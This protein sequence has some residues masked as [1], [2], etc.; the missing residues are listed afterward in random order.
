MPTPRSNLIVVAYP[1]DE[2]L[3]FSSVCR[4]ATIVVVGDPKWPRH[5]KALQQELQQ[6][7]IQLKA[8]K[9]RD[10]GHTVKKVDSASFRTLVKLLRRFKATGRV[11]THSPFD[12]DALRGS[13]ALAAAQAFGEVWVQSPSGMAQHVNV[14]PRSALAAKARII[15]T[16]YAKRIRTED[17]SF[18]MPHTAL[19]GVEAF[20]PVT[21][22]EVMH[23]VALTRSE[24]LPY[25]DAW[26]LMTSP[27]ETNRYERSCQL[28]L[29]HAASSGAKT[30]LEVGACEG[31]M[32]SHLRQTFP[33]SHI[34]ALE[35]HPEFARRLKARFSKDKRT[36]VI[37]QG[38]DKAEL[39]ADIVL[40]AEVLYYVE[41]DLKAILQKVK[42][43]YVLTSS[44]GDFDLELARNLAALKW[45]LLAKETIASCFEAISGG[46]GHL[47][48]RREGTTLRVWQP[49]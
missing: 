8:S 14:L 40:L 6:A 37:Q 4:N 34:K 22:E 36:E 17:D 5:S 15:N 21:F 7:A 11:Y 13:V 42:A 2:T 26:G 24:I 30:I 1:S 31:A 3:G 48:C 19:L 12:D 39:K 28:L 41:K 32:T 43:R 49:A 25:P 38:I 16:V 10:L 18:R 46:H 44:E 9:A 47:Y 20:T 35:V 45:R 23:G 33:Q 29:D 27:Y